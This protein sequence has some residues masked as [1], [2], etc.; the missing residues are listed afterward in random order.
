MQ[1]FNDHYEFSCSAATLIELIQ[2]EGHLE[3]KHK[4]LDA[5]IHSQKILVQTDT[6]FKTKVA[7]KLRIKDQVPAA[8]RALMPEVIILSQEFTWNLVP[9]DGEYS[10]RFRAW[11]EGVTGQLDSRLSLYDT[12]TGSCIVGEGTVVVKIPFVGGKVEA[13]VAE[14]AGKQFREDLAAVEQLALQQAG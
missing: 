3:E 7:R 6:T 2:Q 14:N 8:V 9:Q 11:I 4:L 13:M 5:D 1:T 10:G 12:E